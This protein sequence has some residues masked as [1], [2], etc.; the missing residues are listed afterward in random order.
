MGLFP[1][2]FPSFCQMRTPGS[3]GSTF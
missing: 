1:S 3:D 2:D